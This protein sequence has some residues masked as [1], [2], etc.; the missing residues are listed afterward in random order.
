MGL[1]HCWCL[2]GRQATPTK[3]IERSN[4]ELPAPLLSLPMDLLVYVASLL[5]TRA[6]MKLRYV[7]RKLRSVS[8]TP[9]LWRELIV[10][11]HYHPGDEGC[12]NNVLKLYGQHVKRLSFPQHVIPSK[13]VEMLGRCDNMTDLSLPAAKLNH[14][15][16]QKI[17][18]VMNN[19][20]WLDVQWDIEIRQ[21]AT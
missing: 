19:L 18:P 13:T 1:S 8:E 10:W 21:L 3:A 5:P 4:E 12:V 11:P 20:Q 17:F 16:L 15:Q 9:S 2:S 6:K 14:Q 7:S